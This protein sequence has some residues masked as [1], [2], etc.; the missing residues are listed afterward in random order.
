VKGK[1][2]RVKGANQIVFEAERIGDLPAE[3]KVGG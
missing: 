1:I 2:A 3:P